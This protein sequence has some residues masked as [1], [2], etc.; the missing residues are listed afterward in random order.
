[1]LDN[2]NLILAVFLSVAILFGFHLLT[3][4][5]HP[6]SAPVLSSPPTQTARPATPAA[7]PGTLPGAGIAPPGVG[8]TAPAP[9]ATPAARAPSGALSRAQILAQSP[10]V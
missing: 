10:R 5:L 4:W 6:P 3:Q 7:P 2:K 9:G 8:T 1:M